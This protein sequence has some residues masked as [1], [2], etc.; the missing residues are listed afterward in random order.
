M[1]SF[2]PLSEQ[3]YSGYIVTLNKWKSFEESP[4]IQIG[5][6]WRL[7]SPLDLWTNLSLHLTQKDF[8]NIK[9]CFSLAFKKGNPIIEPKDK[10]DFAAYFNKQKKYSNW[11]REGITQSLILVGRFGEGLS[12]PNLPKPETMFFVY[13]SLNSEVQTLINQK[14]SL[15]ISKIQKK[16]QQQN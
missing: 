16:P 3:K 14:K 2:F 1:K 12:I 13:F 10:N 8:Q 11:S 4:I 9:E 15:M 7:T 5:E 6:T